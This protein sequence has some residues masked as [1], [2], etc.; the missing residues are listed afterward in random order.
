MPGH[1]KRVIGIG[2]LAGMSGLGSTVNACCE[3]GSTD[4]SNLHCCS[5]CEQYVCTD[6]L[7]H[8]HACNRDFQDAEKEDA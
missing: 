7:E 1:L 3:C 5:S 8:D 2:A 4:Q 6:C